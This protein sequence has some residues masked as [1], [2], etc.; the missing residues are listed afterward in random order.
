VQRRAAERI[1]R[2]CAHIIVGF[3]SR[4][5]IWQHDA[6]TTTATPT[7]PLQAEHGTTTT[8]MRPCKVRC[9][10][11]DKQVTA[12]WEIATRVRVEIN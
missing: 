4:V 6:T 9:A 11:E 10:K 7:T 12:V 8:T 2:E 5:V 3:V 1:G